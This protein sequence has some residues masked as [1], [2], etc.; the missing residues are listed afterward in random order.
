MSGS[1]PILIVGGGIV[2]SAT[3]YYLK[4]LGATERIIIIEKFRIAAHSSGKA[5]GFLAKTWC[6]GRRSGALARL[7][8]DLHSQIENEAGAATLE[9][10]PVRAVDEDG[11]VIGNEDNCKQVTP[12]LITEYLSKAADE[13]INETVVSVTQDAVCLS[14]GRSL[15][16]SSCVLALGPWS[17]NLKTWFASEYKFPARTWDEQH[18]S[19]V[20][21]NVPYESDVKQVTP[22]LI[23]EYLSKAADEIINE[24]V[25]S[26]TQDAVCLSD[27]RSLEY[28]SCVLA[29]GP[30]S[31]NL[32]TWFASEYKFP[33]R[34]WDEQHA[35]AV[36]ANVPYESDVQGKSAVFSN[37]GLEI[38][39]RPDGSAY[40]CHNNIGTDPHEL[41]PSADDMKPTT[42]AL[43]AI[44]KVASKIMPALADLTPKTT[45]SCCLPIFHSRG[46]T[47]GRLD[48][49]RSIYMGCGHSCWGILQG[50]ATGLALAE[51]IL[52][53]PGDGCKAVG[54]PEYSPEVYRKKASE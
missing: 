52:N 18:A 21:A 24:T 5:G 26:V 38:Y 6:E 33:A 3:A 9:Y 39:P 46:P 42:R 16:Y 14:D 1:P 4:K 50:P 31:N 41:P 19:A 40:V 12:R 25:V 37:S 36:Y 51:M 2:G 11:A 23:T 48:A 27:G 8:Y 7:S 49:Y 30:W 22:R 32:K 13:I 15:E 53:K 43:A 28:S 17:N 29:L 10:R 45:A 47:I 34:T 54:D 44:H 20:Y 35:S